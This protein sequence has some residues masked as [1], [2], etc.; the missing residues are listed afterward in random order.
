M[1]E[2][3]DKFQYTYAAPTEEERREIESIRKDFLPPEKNSDKLA[4]LR[5]LNDRVKNAAMITSLSMGVIGI[6]LFGLGMSL[7]LVWQNYAAGVIVAALGIA[8]MAAATPVYNAVL[9][10]GK[11]KYGE[12]ILRL[13]EEL[14]HEHK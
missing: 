11:K 5:K 14:L 3:N 1:S 10:R 4:R 8:P 12:E 2:K 13:S 9:R 6:L 7:C